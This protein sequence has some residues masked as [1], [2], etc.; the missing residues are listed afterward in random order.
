MQEVDAIGSDGKVPRLTAPPYSG[1]CRKAASEAA[2]KNGICYPQ[3][4]CIIYFLMFKIKK[5]LTNVYRPA[6]LSS[7]NDLE[8][9]ND[10]KTQ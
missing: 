6:M 7:S 9:L 10:G 2:K 8:E 5:Y 1:E 3:T 4:T